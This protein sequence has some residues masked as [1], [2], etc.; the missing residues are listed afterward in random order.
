MDAPTIAAFASAAV[1]LFALLGLVGPVYLRLGK[2]EGEVKA[3]R[4]RSDEQFREARERSDVQFREAG[5]APTR[6]TLRRWRK[7]GG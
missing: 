4:E 1:A 6:N 3:N 2:V 5:N 7:S